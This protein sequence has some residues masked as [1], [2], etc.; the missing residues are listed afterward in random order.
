M[1][2]ARLLLAA[3]SAAVSFVLPLQAQ[4]QNYPTRPIRLISP[5]AAGGA[6]DVLARAIGLKLSTVW[7][8]RS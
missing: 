6:N 8:R 3:L 1:M 7:E 4:A 2:A 5:F